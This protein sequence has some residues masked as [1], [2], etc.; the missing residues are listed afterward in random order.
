M[1]TMMKVLMTASVLAMSAG[2]A[3]AE[4]TVVAV[5]GGKADDQFFAK[6]KRASTMALW[7]LKPMAGLSTI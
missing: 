3:L 1:K 4:G 5:I 6:V 7:L 2:A